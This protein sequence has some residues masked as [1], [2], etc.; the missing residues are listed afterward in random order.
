MKELIMF[1]KKYVII[2][3][4]SDR[5]GLQVKNNKIFITS[6]KRPADS[7]LKRFLAGHLHSELL[8]IYDQIRDEGKVELF[9]NLNFEIVEKIDKKKQRVAKLIGNKILVK[10]N[11]I[12]LPKSALKYII[13]HEIAHTLTKKHNHKFWKI[14]KT[15]YPGFQRGEKLLMR[16]K[17]T[18]VGE[19]GKNIGA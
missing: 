8:K 9:G 17:P 18:A 7:L 1:G 11:A 5:G 14:V 6:S 4:N 16:Y 12:A 2:E 19:N 13:A 15:I 3:Q 10:L